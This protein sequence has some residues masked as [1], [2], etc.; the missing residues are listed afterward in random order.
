ML[1]LV[2]L[3]DHVINL[4]GIL[5]MVFVN[6]GISITYKEQ[7]VFIPASLKDFE[8]FKKENDI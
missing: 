2:K 4:N 3:G 1:S 8:T 7:I 6:D 5:A